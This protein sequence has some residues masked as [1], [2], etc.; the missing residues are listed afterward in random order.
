MDTGIL[1]FFGNPVQY[2]L[3]ETIP[4]ETR[5][6]VRPSNDEV[7]ENHVLFKKFGGLLLSVSGS[8]SK[9][10]HW[11]WQWFS[12]WRTS[13]Q[14]SR[15]RFHL[16]PRQRPSESESLNAS[17]GDISVG[18]LT[19]ERVKK[20]CFAQHCCWKKSWPIFPFVCDIFKAVRRPHQ[21]PGAALIIPRSGH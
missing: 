18:D 5:M 7:A 17:P 8:P 1:L 3:L 15:L 20:H 2:L 19:S 6:R 9:Y 4:L 14:P 10:K 16:H 13:V 11:M 12:H 21:R